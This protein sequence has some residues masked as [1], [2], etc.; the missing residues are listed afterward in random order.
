MTKFCVFCGQRPVGKN[1]EHV[2]PRWLI[3]VTGDPSR[4]VFLGRDWASETL[5]KRQFSFDR[6]T[7]PACE[8]CNTQ[9]AAL[10]GA[11]RP[12][13]E[14]MLALAPVSASQ[15]D[16][17]LDWFDKVR[18]GLW[19]GGLYLNANHLDVSPMFH[20]GSRIAAKDRLLA[21]YRI[22]DDTQAGLSWGATESPLFGLIPS[23]FTLMVNNLE[24]V[25]VSYDFMLSKRLGFPHPESRLVRSGGGE[26]ID[27][28]NGTG[29]CAA[30]PVDFA[31]P[32][33]SFQIWQPMIPW[34]LAG[35]RD[36]GGPSV[37]S[38]Y[39]NSHVRSCCS[40]F[41][42][43]RG[44][45][46]IRDHDAVVRYPDA[47]STRWIPYRAL[48]RHKARYQNAILSAGILESFMRDH[49]DLSQLPQDE[50]ASIQ[51]QIDGSLALHKTI[52]ATFRRQYE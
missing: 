39:D 41:E 22:Q 8:A 2:I 30:P 44:H 31:F 15:F 27:F 13:M 17:L 34:R 12:V 33:G 21:V 51:Q 10:E 4:Q 18:I 29:A 25:S 52:M 16:T 6:F 9:F 48:S 47:P 43:G 24:F 20:I 42:Q 49:A 3:A 37:R 23:C 26:I 19:L 28:A 14:A 7:F 38:L 40:D 46:F 11:T 50:R 36:E 32:K 1:R 35:A 5:E 45:L